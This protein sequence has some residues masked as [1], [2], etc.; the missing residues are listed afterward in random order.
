MDTSAVKP[1]AT[2]V[3][4]RLSK[5]LFLLAVYLMYIKDNYLFIIKLKFTT[6]G[7]GKVLASV[8]AGA[9]AGAVLGILFAPDKGTETRRKI[10]EKGSD[11]AGTVKDKYSEYADVISEKYD[12]AKQKLSGIVSEGQDMGKDLVNQAKN[13]ANAM[14][15]DVRSSMNS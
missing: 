5:C 9:A 11:L 6:M 3:C 1:F 4:K 2:K 10:A 12:T 7:S 13:K 14:Q 8:L 15:S